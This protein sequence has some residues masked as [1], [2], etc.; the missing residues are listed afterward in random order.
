[1]NIAF[2]TLAGL[3][4]GQTAASVSRGRGEHERPRAGIVVA[5]F[6]LAVMSH[7]VLD[8]LPHE[9]PFRALADTLVTTALVGVWMW[10]IEP[11]F[12]ALLLLTILG[13]VLP[14]VIDH[15]PRDI[16]RHFGTHLPELKKI[17]PWHGRGGSG[18]LSGEGILF[19]AHIAS[20]TNHVIVVT[21]CAVALWLTRGVL[22]PR[23]TKSSRRS[24]SG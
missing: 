19:R 21:F 10:L 11:R 6:G 7:G 14:D 5:A 16:N 12:R 3:A 1:L 13:A 15:V 2:H 8:G 17:F 24:T 4:I 22:R 18:S 23:A 20:L 9:Y